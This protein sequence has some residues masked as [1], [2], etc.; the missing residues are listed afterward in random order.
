MLLVLSRTQVHALRGFNMLELP[1]VLALALGGRLWLSWV[2]DVRAFPGTKLIR[3][4]LQTILL[5]ELWI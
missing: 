3:W 5:V 2:R 4:S 1:L